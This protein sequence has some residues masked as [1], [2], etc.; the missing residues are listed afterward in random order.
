MQSEL[1]VLVHFISKRIEWQRLGI[2]S[3]V[4]TIDIKRPTFEKIVIVCESIKN[5]HF[6]GKHVW[7]THHH[8]C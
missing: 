5:V 7:M 6:I 4:K 1:V 8:K 3:E 2:W